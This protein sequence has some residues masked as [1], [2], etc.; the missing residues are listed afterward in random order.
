MNRKNEFDDMIREL[1]RCAPGLETTLDRAYQKQKKR[2]VKLILRPLAGFAACFAAFVL[3][4]NFCTPIAY[5]CSLVPGLRV[6]AEA[7]TFSRSL[8]D[9][10]ENEYVQPMNLTQAKNDITAEIAYLIVD[11]KQINIFY[12]LN[13]E[14]Y[15]QLNADPDI[16]CDEEGIGFAVVS[17]GYAQENGELLSVT[18]DFTHGNVPDKLECTLRVYS[19][20]ISDQQIA[21]EQAVDHVFSDDSY[22][23]PN[24]VTEFNFLLEFDPQFTATGKVFPVNQTVILDDQAITVTSIEVYPTHMRV[25]ISESAS[26]TAWLKNLDFYVET[27]WG[28]KFDPVSSG[29]TATG[30]SDS[31]SMVSYRADS[32]YFYEADRLKLVITGAKWLRKDMETTYLNLATGAHSKLPEGATF[33]SAERQGNSWVVRFRVDWDEEKPMHQLFSHK[34]YDADGNEYEIKQWSNRHGEK[35]KDGRFTYFYDEF[36]LKNFT[37]NEVWLKP[38]YS[39]YWSEEDMIVINIQ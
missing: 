19:S 14:K 11:Q 15:S 20:S 25:E 33:E 29:I 30:S 31:P 24:Y 34:F 35:N 2:A 22:D 13:S 8:T 9:A 18:V 17:H 5:A 1:N 27:D 4:V 39:H 36:P 38:H 26:N 7:V 6:L 21:T 23:L 12:R 28:M 3:L 32:T 37:A 16:R 10:V